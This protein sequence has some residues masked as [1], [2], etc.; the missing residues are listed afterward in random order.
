MSELKLVSPLLDGF[1]IGDPISDHDGVRCCPAMKENSD[2]KYIVKIIS[3]PASQKQLDALL[4]TGAYKDAGA[5]AEYFKELAEDTVKEARLLQ[6]IAKLEGFLSYEGWQIVPMADN[7]IG[8]DVYLLGSYKRSLEKFLRRNTITHLSAVN[9]GIDLCS[10]LSLCRRAGFIYTDL[11]PSNIFISGQREFRIG[12]LGFARLSAMKY[13]SLP[14]KYIS[15]YTPPELHDPLSTLNP[16]V[17]TYAVGMILYQIYNNGT[18]PFATKAPL[19]YLPT[20]LNA[21]YEMA[22][23]IQKACD[24]NPRK[25]YQTPIEMGQAL[26]S[27]MQRNS[28]NDVPIVPPSMETVAAENV[29]TTVAEAPAQAEP[30]ESAPVHVPEEIRFMEDLI[31]DETAPGADEADNLVDAVMTDEVDLIITQ[32]DE[33]ISHEPD[34]TVEDEDLTEEAPEETP[35]EILEEALEEIPVETPE[36][37]LEETPVEAPEEILEETPVETPKEILEESPVEAPEESVDHSDDVDFNIPEG[38]QTAA[39]TEEDFD[40][41]VTFSDNK[42]PY[43]SAEDNLEFDLPTEPSAPTLGVGFTAQKIEDDFLDVNERPKKKRGWIGLVI[44]VLILALLGGGAYY[45]YDHYYQLHINNMEI[46]G[47]EDTITVSLSTDADVSLMKVTCTDTYGNKQELPISDGKVVFTNLTPDTMYKIT[48][49]TE[50]FHQLTGSYSGSYVT[51]EVTKIVDFT[52]KAG[53]VDGSVMLNFTVDGPETQDWIVEYAAEGEK[54]GSVPFTG[55]MVTVNDLTVGKLYTFTLASSSG[56][57]LTGNTSLEYPAT[58]VI[59][60][61]NLTIVSCE[62]GVL[63][64]QW[65]CP[66]GTSTEGWT[67]RCYSDTGYDET[68]TVTETTAQFEGIVANNAYTVEVTAAGMSQNARAFVTANPATI[69]DVQVSHDAKTGLT[70]TW[71]SESEPKDGWL[72]MY[73]VDGSD[74]TE[75]AQCTGTSAV[76]KHVIP[77]ATYSFQIKAADGSTV[78]GGTTEFEGIEATLFNK[79]GMSAEHIQSSICRSPDKDGWT[80]EDV[81]KTDYTTSYT[82]DEKAA[83]VLY[84]SF[85]FY[86]NSDETAVTFVIRN[87]EGKVI[88]TLTRTITKLWRDLWPG[89][90]KYC[91]LDIPAMPTADGQYTLDVYFDGATMVTKNFSIITANG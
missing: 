29:Q 12:D 47:F 49:V 76:I 31:S 32:A 44:F 40:F 21:D 8:Y 13:T 66:A 71:K 55:H 73:S 42:Y 17:D 62:D 84:A 1:V 58:K 52:A 74:T 77:N 53:K 38:A 33:L 60:A 48:V 39:D 7:E 87:A 69:T 75:M 15:R 56:L 81:A 22:E 20:P 67:V 78:F 2:D 9:L 68:I 57:Y 70:I 79:H 36:E 51:S 25:R 27:Y 34:L 82:A 11:K 85:R 64:T 5:A 54:P 59:V 6:Q 86:L 26:V 16:T 3:V 23:I 28:V 35:E 43:A 18:L 65:T 19:R 14:S 90:G 80:Y 72:V 91:Y 37:A 88:P 89:I 41:N 10:A 50:G 63:T 4:L 30:A 24:P 83:L 45:Y 46:N 61:E